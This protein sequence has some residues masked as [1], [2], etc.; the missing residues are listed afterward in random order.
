MA[1]LND[2]G[3]NCD[4]CRVQQKTI[5]INTVIDKTNVACLY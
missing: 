5:N 2:K 1:A 3:Y 4:P